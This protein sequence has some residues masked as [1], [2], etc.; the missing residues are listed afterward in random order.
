VAQFCGWVEAGSDDPS[1]AILSMVA[2]VSTTQAAWGDASATRV[3]FSSLQNGLA[4]MIGLPAVPVV[5]S[6]FAQTAAGWQVGPVVSGVDLSPAWTAEFDYPKNWVVDVLKRLERD[7][8]P[9]GPDTRMEIRSSFPRDDIPMPCLS[10]QFEASPQA[11]GILGNVAQ[12]MAT[13]TIEKR[14]QWNVSLTEQVWCETPEDRDMLGPWFG[15]VMQALVE[16]APFT[17]LAEPTYQFQESEDFSRALM[18]KP[19]FLL[20]GTLSGIVWSKI[21]IPVRNW[22]GHLTV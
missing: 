8:Q 16:L 5:V 14:I 3:D 18:E 2:L 6:F 19:L 9:L 11:Q 7:T 12:S 4:F 17:N 10:V 20:T 13:Q 21:T 22:I 15:G 1:D